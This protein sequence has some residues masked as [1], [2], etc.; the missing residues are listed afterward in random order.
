LLPRDC[1]VVI[2]GAGFG[3]L[4]TARELARLLPADDRRRITL[5][6]EKNFLLFT[7][8][9]TEVAGG[10]LDARDI[11]APSRQISPQIA[12]EQG[13]VTNIDL[14]SRSVTLEVE[15]GVE[16]TITADHL[17]IALG[18][19]ANY[20]GIPG[21]PQHSLAMKAMPDA[22]EIRN[23]VLA[24]LERAATEK[25]AERRRDILTFVVAGGG[26]TG[27]ETM[28]AINDLARE[29]TK[30]YPSITADEVT[31]YIVDPGKR[32]LMELNE[33]L[34]AFAQRKL[35]EHGVR[36]LLNTR[37][38]RAGD[39]FVELEGGRRIGTHLMIW[40]G[41]VKPNPLVEQLPYRKGKHGGIA[42]DACCGVPGFSGVWALGD[43]AEVPQN[44][45]EGTYAPTA[46]NATREGALV[47]R[48]IVAVL[49]SEAPRPFAF[50]TI[51][52]L[53]LV[54][55]HAGVGEIYG[56][57]FSGLLAWAMWRIVYLSKMPGMGRRSRI[58][59]DW[60][61][62]CAF[63]RSIAELPVG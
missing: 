24:A 2:L 49:S 13:R 60:I 45:G 52:E 28:A 8:M 41:G 46:Q 37:L 26:F 9:L 53:A 59:L 21:V 57:Q 62:D 5:V 34:A 29:S 6:D 39:S 1:H 36:V 25:D 12:F 51:G 58:L 30:N 42:V 18:S 11:A 44:Q 15:P 61:L 3:G 17:V 56:C 7:P 32:L 4:N 38:T 63:G 31:T 43:C 22:I 33:R 48:N 35:E 14:A 16:R 20:H 23:R 19:V 40:A 54:G 10:E 47:A 55:R 27:V 50:H